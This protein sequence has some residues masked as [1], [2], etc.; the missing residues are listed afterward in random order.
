MKASTVLLIAALATGLLATQTTATAQGRRTGQKT[1]GSTATVT[2]A[3]EQALTQ[4][5][6]SLDGEYAAYAE[7]AAII[8]TYG[9]V[10]PYVSILRAEACHIAALQKQMRLR[11][12]AVPEN[13]YLG[14]IQPPATLKA[15]AETA[16]VAE[17]RNVALYDNLLAQV[18]D[19]PQ[20][21]QVFTHLQFASRE[22]HLPA[23]QTAAANDGQLPADQVGCGI[24]CGQGQRGQGACGGAGQGWG[25]GQG[26]KAG[27]CGLAGTAECPGQTK[28]GT[29]RQMRA[30]QAAQSE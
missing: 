24:G 23:F 25:R 19:Q 9:E 14:K 2:P 8:E 7:Y 17:Q 11:G 26:G 6:M 21:V 10:Q 30:G 20:L 1:G 22:H 12:L 16:V 13:P 3:V 4:A 18:K 28:A 15:A 29:G 5:L 27:A